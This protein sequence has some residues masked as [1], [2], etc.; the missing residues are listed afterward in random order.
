MRTF[1]Q[2]LANVLFVGVI[3]YTVW[4]AVTFFVFLQTRSVFAT[5]VIAGLFLV[6]M[7]STGV[8][9]GSLVDHHRKKTVMQVVRAGVARLLRGLP[10]PVPESR[11]RRRGRTRATCGSGR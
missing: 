4:F 9:F 2:L 3:N 1:V 11:R 8:W 10:R 7:V 6:A 5:G